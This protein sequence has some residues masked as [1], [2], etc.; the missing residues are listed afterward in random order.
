MHAHHAGLL[1]GKN[2]NDST[3]VSLILQ[4]LNSIC[5]E[6]GLAILL[7][8]HLNK[9]AA[10][11]EASKDGLEMH[12]VRGSSA[13]SAFC[14]N[15]VGI[16]NDEPHCLTIVS[17]TSYSTSIV[18]HYFPSTVCFQIFQKIKKMTTRFDVAA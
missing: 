8:H 2:E 16:G 4:T 10:A 6:F 3:E 13:I 7:V 5:D 15:I 9:S 11:P 18:S 1:A 14:R 12:H 17:A